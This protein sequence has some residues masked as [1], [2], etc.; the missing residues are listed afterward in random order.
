[1]ETGGGRPETDADQP[2][3]PANVYRNPIGPAG[4][5][6]TEVVV[7]GGWKFTDVDT[8]AGVGLILLGFGGF[9]DRFAQDQRTLLWWV[10]LA[11]LA[12][13]GVLRILIAVREMG[14]SR[15]QG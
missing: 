5:G 2:G 9:A 14:R 6:P 4:I 12:I 7:P 15:Q 3:Q 8:V 11:L 13:W 1:M 10:G